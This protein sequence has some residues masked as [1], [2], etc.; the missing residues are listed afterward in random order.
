MP[1]RN[2]SGSDSTIL[3]KKMSWNVVHFLRDDT[4][5][6]VPES[7]IIKESKQ[8]Y[9]PSM[10]GGKLKNLIAKCESPCSEWETFPIRII[11]NAYGSITYTEFADNLITARHKVIK[12]ETTSDLN[13]DLEQEKRIRKKSTLLSSSDSDSEDNMYCVKQMPVF[14]P[15]ASQNRKDVESR[16]QPEMLEDHFLK[17]YLPTEMSSQKSQSKS[18]E[19]S[20]S[21]VSISQTPKSSS[22]Y[23]MIIFI[24]ITIIYCFCR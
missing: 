3:L 7:W 12:A 16:T 17:V 14:Q 18:V 13:S 10:N 23:G 5:E 8:C 1:S 6:A 15:K 2:V 22:E 19:A 20:R 11:G 9:W 24:N 4:V 21:E